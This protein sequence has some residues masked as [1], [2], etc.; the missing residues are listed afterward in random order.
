MNPPLKFASVVIYTDRVAETVA[1]YVRITGL[2]TSYFDTELGFALL[3]ADQAVAIASHAAGEMMLAEG[4]AKV[5]RSHVRSVELAFWSPDV[6]ASFHN[7]IDAGA[8]PLT[9]PRVMPW[10]QTVAYVQAPDGAIIGFLTPI[11]RESG[12]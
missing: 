1:F 5:R 11:E 12:N 2:E 3:G 6:S 10:G 8:T 7:A 9:A 4:Y